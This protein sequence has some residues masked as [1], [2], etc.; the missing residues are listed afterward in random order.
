MRRTIE[1]QEMIEEEGSG[2][3]GFQLG[4]VLGVDF[5]FK[6][7][8]FLVRTQGFKHGA[9][10]KKLQQVSGRVLLGIK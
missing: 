5:L 2:V 7:L 9:K 4:V 10:Q 6:A 1:P 3:E 8:L